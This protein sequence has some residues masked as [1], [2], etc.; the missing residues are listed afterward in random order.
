[1][2]Y[3]RV[4]MTAFGLAALSASF[5]PPC[6]IAQTRQSSA[7]AQSSSEYVFRSTVRR[8]PVDVVVT[9]KDGNPVHGLTIDDFVVQE[10]GKEQNVLS[11]EVFDGTAP[12][13]VPPKLPAMPPN[14]YV[15]L[16]AEAERGP[17]YVLYY[18]MVNTAQEDQMA[19]RAEL[20]R[21]VDNAAPGTR[22]ALFVNAK[23][24]H[25]MQGFTTDHALLR[26]A[27][28]R[29]GP[30]PSIPNVFL[31]GEVYGRYDAGGA[32]SN[33]NFIAEYLSGLPERKNLIWL[34]SYFPIPVGPTVVGI[35]TTIP[36]SPPVSG[37]AGGNGGPAM[38]DLSELL[39]DSIK[40]TYASMMRS[41]IALY[42]VSV[43]GVGIGPDNL[44]DFDHMK[45]IA[46]TTGGHAYYS[47]NHPSLLIDK[48]MQHGESYYT[49]SYSP[50]NTNFDGSER[51]IHVAVADNNKKYTLTYRTVY[52][53][54]SDEEVQASHTKDVKQQQFLAAKATDTLFA[55]VEH[56]APM[57]H[58]VVFV[59]HLA[60]TGEP[61]MATAEQMRSLEDL[62]AFFRTRRH[63]RNPK[64]LT[65]VKLQQYVI[66]YDVIDPRLRALAAAR[67][68]ST[69]LEFAAA[70]YNNDGTLLNSILNQGTLSSAGRTDGKADR[71]F[72][73]VQQLQVPPGAAYIRLVVRNTLNDRTGALEVKL[74]LKPQTQ[75]AAL[76]PAQSGT[77]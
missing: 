28:L 49:L 42:P 39:S 73:A 48:A 59:A 7:A 64:P 60:K 36:S 70:A 44:V 1:M 27:I 41:R 66:D 31:L 17:L 72:H 47:D 13:F 45:M 50:Q 37:Q 58:D 33:L 67:Q 12:S 25:M 23:G 53:A 68:K 51:Q 56:G 46:E 76:N 26:E 65:P 9:N 63:S 75:T 38:L 69:V 74:P 29:K 54:V 22:I 11:F 18:D 43:S 10:D 16:P 32:L 57:V 77:N 30:P 24:L 61:K 20:L 40:H 35:D 52:Y 8:V 4:V 19:F 21:F 15:D 5:V 55:T 6:G 2:K 3:G 62:P 34:A 14:T 71:R